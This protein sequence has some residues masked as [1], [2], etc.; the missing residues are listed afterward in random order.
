M[1][2]DWSTLSTVAIGVCWGLVA[3]VWVIGAVYNALRAPAVRRRSTPTIGWLVGIVAAW[4]IFRGVPDADWRSLTV[5]SVSLRAVGVAILL[6]FT[7]F[8]LWARVVLGTMWT[9]YAAAKDAHVL[10]TDGPYAITRHPIY[11]GILGMLLGTALANGLGLWVPAFL[12]GV[13]AAE[14][15]IRAE[16][17]LLTKVFPESYERYRRQVPQLVPG[18]RGLGGL[19]RR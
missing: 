17:R 16:E 6:P 10:H 2:G 8:T 11:T 4:V 5:Q 9:S 14:I 18:L 13:M 15:K 19:R 12:L 1:H 7:A 3:L